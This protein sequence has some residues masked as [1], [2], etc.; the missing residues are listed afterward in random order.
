MSRFAI[1][2]TNVLVSALLSSNEDSATVRI[3]NNV[4]LGEIIPVVNKTVLNEYREVLS[5]SKFGFLQTLIDYVLSAIEAFGYIHVPEP[6]GTIIPDM[7]DLP[8]Y[9]TALA[10]QEKEAYLITGNIKHFP[11]APFVVTPRDYINQ[12]FE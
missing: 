8:F 1:I 11:N 10:L 9:E 6:S 7:D 2:D 4:F 3:L 12:F 5:R